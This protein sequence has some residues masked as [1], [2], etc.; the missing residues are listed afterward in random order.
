MIYNEE[1]HIPDTENTGPISHK[2]VKRHYPRTNNAQ[3]FEFVFEKD[4]NLFLRKNKIVI[5][6]SV[7]V[8]DGY[9]PEVGFVAKLFGMLTVDVDSH[10]IS[11]NKAKYV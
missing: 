10:T 11:S 7:E 4:P 2:V 5:K 8:D 3:V 1:L 9:V 6:G